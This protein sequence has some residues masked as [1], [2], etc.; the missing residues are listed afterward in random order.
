MDS[1][2][3]APASKNLSELQ[4]YLGL[5]KYYGKCIPLLKKDVKCEWNSE[6]QEIFAIIFLLINN[7]MLELYP[8]NPIVVQME[9]L[10]E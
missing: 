8:T 5:L 3:K 10:M 7:N 4:T 9:V 1:L 2:L 6:E